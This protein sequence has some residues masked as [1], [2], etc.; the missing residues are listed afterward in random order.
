[1]A[2]F[3]EQT[4][5]CKFSL[6]CLVLGLISLAFGVGYPEW[7]L[8]SDGITLQAGLWQICE[9]G[10]KE[11]QVHTL[12]EQE[13]WFDAVRG[14]E[15]L[16]CILYFCTVCVFLK[17]VCSSTYVDGKSVIILSFF[18]GLLSIVGAIVYTTQINLSIYTKLSLSFWFT[19]LGAGAALLAGAF[20]SINR[21][22]YRGNI[23]TPM[24]PQNRGVVK[25]VNMGVTVV[26]QSSAVGGP[27]LPAYS[28]GYDVTHGMQPGYPPSEGYGQRFQGQPGAPPPYS[29]SNSNAYIPGQIE[30][31]G[32]WPTGNQGLIPA[33]GPTTATLNPPIK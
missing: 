33:G 10:L 18:T 12:G 31:I 1:M 21:R 17:Q 3:S 24:P 15:A 22:G 2:G 9:E 16:S 25:P 11:C 6:L 23:I 8:F 29:V 32:A 5:W 27:M 4:G 30:G 19:L 14:I 20:L 28:N 13:I 7:V 26:Q